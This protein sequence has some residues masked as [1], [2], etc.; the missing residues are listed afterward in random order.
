MVEQFQLVSENQDHVDDD[1]VMMTS[2]NEVSEAQEMR[3]IG[4]ISPSVTFSNGLLFDDVMSSPTASRM[5]LGFGSLDI[6]MENDPTRSPQH[7][8]EE[9][10]RDTTDRP[11]KWGWVVVVAS[12]IVMIPIAGVLASFGNIVSSLTEEFNATK[13]EAGWI[14][15][16]AFSFTVGTCPLS[17]PLFTVYGAR[18]VA[19]VGVIGASISVFLTSFIPVLHLMFLTYSAMLG[20]F[21]NFVYNTAMNLTGQYFPNKHQALATCLASAGVSFGTLLIN[22]LTDHLV[23]SIGWRHTL[24]ILA[25]LIL[26]IGLACVATFRP[27]KTEEQKIQTRI[28]KALKQGKDVTS[29]ALLHRK[30]GSLSKVDIEAV[31]ESIQHMH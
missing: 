2:Q 4:A 1:V 6:V 23:G 11:Q 21:A 31:T 29:E 12:W 10:R 14:G 28:K 5:T 3:N 16:L 26:V 17:T 24:K 25:G 19:F 7:V 30:V 27:V 15:S 18:K 8:T 20:I 9:D 22:P 13:M